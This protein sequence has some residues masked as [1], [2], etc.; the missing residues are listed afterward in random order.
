MP[1]EVTKN[2]TRRRKM[3]PRRCSPR[4]FRTKRLSKHR[5]IVVCCPKGHWKRGRCQVGMK[6]QSELIRKRR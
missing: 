1:V 4:S 5:T 3:S 6:L 2:Y